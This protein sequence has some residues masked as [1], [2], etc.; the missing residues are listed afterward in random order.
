[1]A[2]VGAHSR[3]ING[4]AC[5]H[6]K[7]VFA[8]CGDDTFLNVWEVVSSQSKDEIDIEVI[9]SSRTP[10]LMLTGVSFGNPNENSVLCSVYDYKQLLVWDDIF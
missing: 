1:M 5:H 9:C 4:L 7:S 3:Q 6:K 2:E 8:T 10:D